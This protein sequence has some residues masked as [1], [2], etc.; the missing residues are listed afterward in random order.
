MSMIACSIIESLFL[1]FWVY[2]RFMDRAFKN[3]VFIRKEKKEEHQVITTV[4]KVYMHC[5]ACSQ[6]I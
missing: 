1:S 4:L 2:S 5:E 3:V 6:E